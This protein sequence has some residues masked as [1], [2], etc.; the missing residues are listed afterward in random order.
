MVLTDPDFE[1][2][3]L[4]SSDEGASY[5]KYRLT[6]YV[7]SLLFH[8]TEEDWALAYSHDQKV[9]PC[10]MSYISFSDLPEKREAAPIFPRHSWSTELAHEYSYLQHFTG[11]SVVVVNKL[12]NSSTNNDSLIGSNK[13]ISVLLL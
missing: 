4:I 7:L 10:E 8:P 6:F 1:S 5:Q 2:S 3:V 9:R 13:S 12:E 11:I